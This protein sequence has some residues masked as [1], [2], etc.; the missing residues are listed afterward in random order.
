MQYKKDLAWPHDFFGV[1]V[2]ISEERFV[3]LQ[4]F[5]PQIPGG[6]NRGGRIHTGTSAG[7]VVRLIAGSGDSKEPGYNFRDGMRTVCPEESPVAQ[8]LVVPETALRA[9]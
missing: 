6:E 7:T 8:Y 5:G 3:L 2:E 1:D 4:D 9:L